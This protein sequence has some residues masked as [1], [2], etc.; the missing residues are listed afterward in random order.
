MYICAMVRLTHPPAFFFFFFG[1]LFRIPPHPIAS[2]RI[3]S[4]AEGFPAA[5]RIDWR[6]TR[7]PSS[8][9]IL[10]QGPRCVSVCL[11]ACVPVCLCMCL[12]MCLCLCLCLCRV[13]VNRSYV[14]FYKHPFVVCFPPGWLTC[15]EQ[16]VSLCSAVYF[17]LFLSLSLYNYISFPSR[18][19][20]V[21]T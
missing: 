11:S 20:L 8:I 13:H 1:V 15:S 12:C 5:S 21:S 9:D 6:V 18:L 3:A 17:S 16:P 19:S 4:H 10:G 14:F 7:P 2:H